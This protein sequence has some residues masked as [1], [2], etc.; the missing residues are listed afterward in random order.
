METGRMMP[1]DPSPVMYEDRYGTET[2][3]TEDGRVTKG[4]DPHV[5]VIGSKV[6]GWRSHFATCPYAN[7]FR[8]DR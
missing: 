2:I 7:G 5:A 6:R 4:S 8:R 3:V 1:V